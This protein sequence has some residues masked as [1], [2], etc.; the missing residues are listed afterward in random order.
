[1]DSNLSWVHESFLLLY[2]C[3]F[4][5]YFLFILKVHQL[6][7]LNLFSVFNMWYFPHLSV[8]SPLCFGCTSALQTTICYPYHECISYYS[9]G[10]SSVIEQTLHYFCIFSAFSQPSQ[11]VFPAMFWVFYFFSCLGLCCCMLSFSSCSVQASHCG[12]FASCR[13]WALGC[14]LQQLWHTGLVAL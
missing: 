1:M 4:I 9:F 13:A 14:R 12:G 5:L 11:G 3:L 10:F 8:F 7:I 2:L 6:S